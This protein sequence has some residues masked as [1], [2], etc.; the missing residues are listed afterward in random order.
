MLAD[1]Y[2]DARFE[3]VYMFFYPGSTARRAAWTHPRVVQ[4]QEGA[5]GLA[6]S[7]SCTSNGAGDETNAEVVFAGRA[8]IVRETR[9]LLL[10]AG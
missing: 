4:A 5:R 10:P 7:A 2:P 1:V 6:A 9:G 8:R 3:A